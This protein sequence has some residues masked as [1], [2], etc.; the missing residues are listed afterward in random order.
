LTG[1]SAVADEAQK[2]QL[3]LETDL[4]EKAAAATESLQDLKEG[5]A[6][7]A[8][9][10][11]EFATATQHD[12]D[13]VQELKEIIEFLK[14]RLEELAEE[15]KQGAH[16]EEQFKDSSDL[17]IKTLKEKEEILSRLTKAER[18]W[19]K[20]EDERIEKQMRLE[21]KLQ[22]EFEKESAARLAAYEKEQRELAK[23]AE[24]LERNAAAQIAAAQ[25]VRA[26]AAEQARAF[27]IATASA[28]G[29]TGFG[30]GEEG[31]GG[32][33]GVSAGIL[34]LERASVGLATGHGLRGAT[35][36]LEALALA[37]GGPAGVGLAIGSIV[38]FI[39]VVLPKLKSLMEAMI[40]ITESTKAASRALQEQKD[41]AEK[42]Q[43]AIDKLSKKLPPGEEAKEITPF[44][45]GKKTEELESAIVR[46][47]E[48]QGEG[49]PTPKQVSVATAEATDIF[50]QVDKDALN[51]NLKAVTDQNR[52]DEANRL[53]LAAPHSQKARDRLREIGRDHPDI[54]PPGFLEKLDEV[55]PEGRRA[56]VEQATTAEAQ[57]AEAEDIYEQREAAAK[58]NEG[59]QQQ[60]NKAFQDKRKLQ[61][62]QFESTMQSDEAFEKKREAA[63][64]KAKQARKHAKTEAAR[65]ASES[66][67]EAI[68]RR[69]EQEERNEIDR[70]LEMQRT[71]NAT[72]E[73]MEEARRGAFSAEHL[74]ANVPQSVGLGIEQAQHGAMSRPA[75]QVAIE[76][77]NRLPQTGGNVAAAIEQAIF[78]AFQRGQQLN[79]R[80]VQRLQVFTEAFVQ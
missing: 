62:K 19:E 8:K 22:S 44:T 67:P 48:L 36:A 12:V 56:A 57:S 33:A 40:G 41:Q 21:A 55:S 20:A 76:A 66:T 2:I 24:V 23:Q 1:D 72:P 61:D 74:G 59:I 45:E 51:K 75:E 65:Q 46:S 35:S 30:E 3:A 18:D 52:I 47:M 63:E 49:A 27:A 64:A 9:Q 71:A 50:G 10:G 37:A 16:S 79:H 6:E 69:R 78:A 5:M 58:E 11:D 54:F 29:L 42:N 38:T 73:F 43:E 17:L 13:K 14:K 32:L 77:L 26:T 15:Y 70:Q 60:F 80:D 39:D 31:K 7:V 25:A 53:I 68:R 28:E 34:K 4:P